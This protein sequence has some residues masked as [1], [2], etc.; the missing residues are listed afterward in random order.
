ML[1][2]FIGLPKETHLIH[3]TWKYCLWIC[4]ENMV[5]SKSDVI[6]TIKQ[7]LKNENDYEIGL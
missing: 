2:E 4:S 5:E 7:K 6:L 3:N 1:I